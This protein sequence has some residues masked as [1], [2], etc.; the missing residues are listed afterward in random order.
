VLDVH[1]S[2]LATSTALSSYY[3]P[4]FIQPL[5][6]IKVLNRAKVKFILAG[7][8]GIGGWMNKPRAT[9]DVD[10]LLW[11][12]HHKKGLKAL[13][14][15]YP[16]LELEE[17]PVVTRLRD[18]KSGKIVIDLMKSDQGVF[19]AAFQ[20]THPIEMEGQEFLIP[21]LEMALV[22]KFAPMVSPNRLEEDKL[23]DIHDFIYMVKANPVID[24]RLLE[25]LGEMTYPG[26]GK[27]ILDLVGKVRSG[28]NLIL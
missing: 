25:E 10:V 6:V 2:S 23:Q 14:E 22:M 13:R 11:S 8:H 1:V 18:P 12:R 21:S 17:L 15:A 5:D 3:V 16:H 24:S 20:H 4:E 27:E 9:Q 19:R 28:K 7:L 26:G